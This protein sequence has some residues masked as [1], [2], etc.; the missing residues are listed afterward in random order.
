MHIDLL[1]YCHVFLTLALSQRVSILLEIFHKFVIDIFG[2]PN[3]KS[4]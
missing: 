2:V 4:N 3:G 1:V